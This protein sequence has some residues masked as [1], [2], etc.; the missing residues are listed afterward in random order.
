MMLLFSVLGTQCEAR[1]LVEGLSVTIS[2]GMFNHLHV[3]PC[4][5]PHCRAESARMPHIDMRVRCT[6]DSYGVCIYTLLQCKRT[7]LDSVGGPNVGSCWI[8]CMLRPRFSRQQDVLSVKLK[9]DV[10]PMQTFIAP[11]TGNYRFEVAGGQGGSASGT[12]GGLGATV[13]ATVSLLQG[14]NVPIIV[15]GQGSPA[16]SFAQQPGAGGGGLSAVYTNGPSAPATIVAGTVPS[17]SYMAIIP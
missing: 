14:A 4:V 15:A 8:V 5:F 7:L 6:C 17:L 10:C 2:G 13:I 12:V 11:A 1:E 9:L 3:A 16:G